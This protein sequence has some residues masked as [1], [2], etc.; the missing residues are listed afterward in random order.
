MHVLITADTLGGVWIYTRELV[1][2]L[3]RRGVRVTLVSFGEIPG[4]EQT[5]WLDGLPNVD[6]RPTAFRLEWMQD[7]EADL[8]AS[9]EYLGELVRDVNPEL[10][11]LNQYCYGSLPGDL[12]RLVV[13]HS[14]VLSWWTAV[15]GGPPPDSSWIRGYREMVTSGLSRATAVVTPSRWMLDQLAEH[16]IRPARASV[17]CNGRSP[18]LFEANAAKEEYMISV[19]RLWDCGKQV[20]LLTNCELPLKAV[21]VGSAIH[22]DQAFRAAEQ[23]QSNR[24]VQF[25]GPQT[26]ER[27]RRLFSHAAIYAA[28]S[29]YEPF[30]LAPVEAALSRCAIVANDIPSFRELWGDAACY[31]RQNDAHSLASE[32]ARLHSDP[33][34]CR[35]YAESAYQRA[36]QRLSADRMVEDYMELYRTLASLHP[37]PH[38]TQG[39]FGGVG[40]AA[41]A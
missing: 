29:R 39:W 16:Y 10:L 26:P 37:R 21:V 6:F 28:T 11:H 7:S 38:Q 19:G 17:I 2:G 40:G 30:G 25:V 23:N 22:P 20:S 35:K 34:L 1:S 4:P 15:H 18:G 31:F 12:P 36:R 9:A 13:A 5:A 41:V 14:D 24:R 32:L 27:L 3:A 33:V 8:E